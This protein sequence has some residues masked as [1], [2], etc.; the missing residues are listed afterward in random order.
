M[1][2]EHYRPKIGPRR[3]GYY[4][5]YYCANCGAGGL[6]MYGSRNHGQGICERNKELVATLHE[7]NTVEAEN[8]REFTRKLKGQPSWTR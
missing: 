1:S 6:S 7:L 3:E 4:Q 8:K 5:G 2:M